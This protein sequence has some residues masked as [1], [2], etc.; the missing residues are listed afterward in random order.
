[1]QNGQIHTKV[2]KIGRKMKR[3][4][5]WAQSSVGEEKLPPETGHGYSC[6]AVCTLSIPSTNASDSLRLRRFLCSSTP[7]WYCEVCVRWH[8]E[9]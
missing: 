5:A 8:L 7:T 6:T 4:L 1:M 3:E 2:E 9:D